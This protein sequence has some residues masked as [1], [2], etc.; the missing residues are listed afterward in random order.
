MKKI[1]LSVVWGSM[2]FCTVSYAQSTVDL[3]KDRKTSFVIVVSDSASSTVEKSAEELNL[4]M[5]KISGVKLPVVKVSHW[6][7]KIP[8][9]AVGQSALTT[10]N[11]WDKEPFDQEEARVF[12]E[13]G[14][15]GLL[16]NDRSPYADV[17]WQGTYY[18]VNE[19]VRK[20]LGVRWIWATELGEVYEKRA[21]ISVKKEHWNWKPQLKLIRELRLPGSLVQNEATLAYYSSTFNLDLAKKPDWLDKRKI[22]KDGHYVWADRKRL[23]T[24]SDVRFGH[25]FE[26]WWQRFSKDHP[27]WFARPPAGLTQQG[28]KGVKLN[29]SNP[30]VH[31][32]II[33]DWKTL[34]ETDP[35]RNRYLTAG[36]NDSRGFD[37]RPETRAWDA[38][39]MQRY[40]DKE[41][42]NGSE[43]ILSD[44]HVK[45]WN[46]LA[47]RI[48]KISPEAQFATYAYRNYRKPPLGDEQLENNIVIAYVGGEGY[49]P[50]ETYIRDEWREWARRGARMVWRP[51]LFH[52][53]HGAPYLYS[54]SLFKDM[55]F[56]MQQG[57]EGFN[58]DSMVGNWAGQGLNYYVASEIHLRPDVD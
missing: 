2:C 42:Y 57:M 4:W 41:I 18:A 54:E 31:D 21:S 3:V 26:N 33:R 34:W 40:S 9:I 22:L 28:G 6:D 51:N 23:G 20:S 17:E 14:K 38:P 5:E 58:F 37:T 16:G 44:R 15:I 32:Q 52:A 55:Q 49:Y 53:G 45:L 24:V 47:R 30:E 8:Y 10:K 43:P 1:L 7:G 27:D 50:D 36:P 19:F 12:I 35:A 13:K 25:A 11:G 48:R 39:E 56:F 46:I 29:I